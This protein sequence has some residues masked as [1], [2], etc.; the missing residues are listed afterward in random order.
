MALSSGEVQIHPE[1]AKI[2]REIFRKYGKGH[3]SPQDIARRLSRRGVATPEWDSESGEPMPNWG[4]STI[5]GI[6]A[7]AKYIGVW[8]QT[9]NGKKVV[10]L[11]IAPA[12]IKNLNYCDKIEKRL[13][14]LVSKKN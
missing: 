7:N 3:L 6:L 14:E 5:A 1:N 10:S 8:E 12:I 13:I 4:R 2:V 11:D 9:V